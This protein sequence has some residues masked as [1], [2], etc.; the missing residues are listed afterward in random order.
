MVALFPAVLTKGPTVG[1]G[2]FLAASTD[3]VHWTRPLLLVPS[4]NADTDR[5]L[6]W[7]VDGFNA[8]K[9]GVEF[10]VEHNIKMSHALDAA[11]GACPP[12]HKMPRP[13]LRAYTFSGSA[14][15]TVMRQAG[16]IAGARPRHAVGVDMDIGL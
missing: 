7:V 10:L 12:S 11:D 14:Y 9:E 13:H 1:S 4:K 8:T 15:A 2:T 16:A 6:D 3:G 5:V